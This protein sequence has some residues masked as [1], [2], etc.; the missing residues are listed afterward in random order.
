M[1][2]RQAGS[3][4]R[5]AGSTLCGETAS[6]TRKSEIAELLPQEIS[7]MSRDELGQV[8][9]SFL[10]LSRRPSKGDYQETDHETLQQ[11]VYR[12]RN[13]CRSQGY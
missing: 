9:D 13:C 3:S 7:E 8:V 11:L 4:A 5:L 6:F 12:A 10:R 2:A 1:T